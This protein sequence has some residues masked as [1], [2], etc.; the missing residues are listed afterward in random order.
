MIALGFGKKWPNLLSLGFSSERPSKRSK[1][2]AKRTFYNERWYDSKAE[3]AHS[4]KL[5][6]RKE[7]GEILDIQYQYRIKIAVNG[8]HWRTYVA[9]FRV[10]LRDGTIQYQDVKGVSTEVFKMKWDMLHILRGDILEPGAELLI[11][12]SK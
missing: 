12:P 9:D 1:Y 2:G 4:R 3:A 8:K 10:V 7:A 6:W 5:D 11:I